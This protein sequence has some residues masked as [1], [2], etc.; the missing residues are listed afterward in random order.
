MVGIVPLAMGSASVLG[1]ILVLEL[2]DLVEI[3]R[4]DRK[5][6]EGV[7]HHEDTAE[8]LYRSGTPR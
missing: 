3:A 1:A 4:R 5:G 7:L 2:D 6:K 8:I